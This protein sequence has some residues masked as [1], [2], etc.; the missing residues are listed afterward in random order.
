MEE[1]SPYYRTPP[2]PP[3]PGSPPPMPMYL[4]PGH[5]YA[6]VVSADDRSMGMI[7]HLL[8]ILTGFIGPLIIWL[9]KKQTSPF[10][11]HHGRE[12]LK[13]HGSSRSSISAPA[14]NLAIPTDS[15][16][17]TPS[18]SV[19]GWVSRP[20]RFMDSARSSRASSPRP[21]SMTTP[22]EMRGRIPSRPV[23]P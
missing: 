5:G 8:A 15:I 9:V 19:S 10:L 22:A 21:S 17:P 20:P 4:A 2:P 6:P 13:S 16:H 14:T 23:T 11:D 18:R 3:M 1:Q 12:A 7:C